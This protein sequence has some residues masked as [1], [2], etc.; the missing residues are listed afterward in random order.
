[1]IKESVLSWWGNPPFFFFIYI[2]Y[3]EILDILVI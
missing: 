1:L 3:I 2:I